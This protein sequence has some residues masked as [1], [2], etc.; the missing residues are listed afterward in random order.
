MFEPIERAYVS[1]VCYYVEPDPVDQWYLCECDS[2]N[3]YTG[4]LMSHIRVVCA[5]YMYR[6][7]LDY[8]YKPNARYA[9]N[10]LLVSTL[11]GSDNRP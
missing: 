2:M 4:N 9:G 5:G 6:G 8:A 1:H 3:A 7:L 10:L 11:P